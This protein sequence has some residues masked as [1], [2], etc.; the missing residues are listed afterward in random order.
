[1]PEQLPAGAAP[2]L[3]RADAALAMAREAGADD[4]LARANRS[5]NVEYSLRDGVLEKVQQDTSRG[6]SIELYVDGRY[7]SHSTSDLRPDSLRSFVAEAVAM[8]R[9]LAPDPHRA[10]PDPAL[11]PAGASP[12]LGLTDSAVATL[13]KD[14]R[15]ARLQAMADGLAGHEDIISWTAGFTDH[16]GVSGLV[17]TNGLRTAVAG[18]SAWCGVE[19][20]LQDPSGSRPEDWYWGGG[21]KVADL[22]GGAEVAARCLEQARARVGTVKGPTKKTLLIVDPRSAGRLAGYLLQAASA[23]SIQQGRS[24]W[25]DK[26]D[27]KLFSEKLSLYDAPL[28]VGGLS[29]R[30]YDGEGLASRDLAIVENGVVKNVYVD[31]YYGRKAGMTPTTGGRSNLRWGHGT[32]D[33][34]A[35]VADVP[36]AIYLTS[37]LGGN[38]DATSGDFSFGLRGHAITDGKVGGPIGEMNVTGNLVDLFASLV[39]TGNDPYQYSSTYAPTL[40]FEGVQFSGA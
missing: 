20:T 35:I 25:T 3:E 36:D 8:T 32:R 15:M 16:Q 18:T 1:M 39:E 11:Y 9:V 40:V 29:S 6:L 28:Q 33:L 38:A 23:R 4:A 12:D 24:F 26:L 10:L 5:R 2:L 17:S 21:H 37:W 22:P 7:S 30:P 27:H 34:S 13:N 31:T 14:A 19:V